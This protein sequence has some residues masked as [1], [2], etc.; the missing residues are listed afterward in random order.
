[1]T[2]APLNGNHDILATKLNGTA[3]ISEDAP[4]SPAIDSPATPVDDSV[5][6]N[7]KIDVQS[8]D[9]EESDVRHELVTMK[10]DNVENASVIPQVSTPADP[11]QSCLSL[12]PMCC[13][14]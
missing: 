7:V 8:N 12:W 2:D 3:H 6:A 14:S 13:R 5:S 11:G 10:V 4:E 1:M 9:H